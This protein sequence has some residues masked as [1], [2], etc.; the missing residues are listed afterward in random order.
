M[1]RVDLDVLLDNANEHGSK[2]SPA[3]HILSFTELQL[4]GYLIAFNERHE[5]CEFVRPMRLTYV[6][7]HY[8]GKLFLINSPESHKRRMKT[9]TNL[10]QTLLLSVLRW[11]DT[12][13]AFQVTSSTPARLYFG[14]LEMTIFAWDEL[15]YNWFA[16]V[17]TPKAIPF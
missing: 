17:R 1:T 12:P 8:H 6:P 16:S 7:T 2:L 3:T 4:T 15:E 14:Q 11:L 10:P 5:H 9:A 13:Q